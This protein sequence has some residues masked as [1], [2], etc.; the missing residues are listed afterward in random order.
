MNYNPADHYVHVMA[1][2]P[3]REEECRAKV[4][5]ICD[6]FEASPEGQSVLN[7]V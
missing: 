5:T 4:N 7:E 3:G 2:T 6:A 1:V